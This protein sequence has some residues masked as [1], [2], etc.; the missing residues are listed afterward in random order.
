VGGNRYAGFSI[1][2]DDL[3][4]EPGSL[5][6]ARGHSMVRKPLLDAALADTARLAAGLREWHGP[7]GRH[8]VCPSCEALRLHDELVKPS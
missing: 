7:A 2:A 3:I 6:P 1:D 8:E 5:S 4:G